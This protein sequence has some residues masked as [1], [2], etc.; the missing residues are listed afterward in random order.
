MAGEDRAGEGRP[1]PGSEAA[2][3]EAD[4]VLDPATDASEPGLELSQH[5]PL[6]HAEHAQRYDRQELIQTYEATFGCR[7]VVV[8]D[9]I[10]G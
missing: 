8:I 2:G 6:F 10:F 4:D 7:L 5:S 1:P 3:G 9:G